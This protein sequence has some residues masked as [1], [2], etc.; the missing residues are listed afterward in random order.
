M[1]GDLLLVTKGRR[2]HEA[3]LGFL[4]AA[5]YWSSSPKKNASTAYGAY[6]NSGESTD[7]LAIQISNEDGRVRA[8]FVRCIKN[9]YNTPLTININ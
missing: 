9:D 8:R 6:I 2:D 5:S 7:K 3:K 1:V 4:S